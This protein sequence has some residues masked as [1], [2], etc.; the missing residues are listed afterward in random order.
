MKEWPSSVFVGLDEICIGPDAT[1]RDAIGCIDRS[2]RAIAL[3][4]DES[5]RLLDTI[6]DGDVRRAMLANID[7][8]TPVSSLQP[9]RRT[10]PY[11]NPVTALVSA[12]ASDVLQTM[13]EQ[14][15]RQVPLLDD[16][17]R[18]VGLVTRRDLAP[19][20]KVRLEAVV[21]AGGQGARLRPL[22]ADTPKPMLQ[23]AGRPL[24][25]QIIERLEQAGIR[26][27]SIAT[28]YQ[29]E[30]IADHFGDGRAFGI[31][32]SYVHEDRPL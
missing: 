5:H 7:L 29:A 32:L 15:L 2:L 19:S 18:V 26:R 25:E 3:V 27:V 14:G 20:E 16:G 23:V 13:E 11:P 10:S 21:M 12:D 17:R 31:D 28:H 24:M 22:T 8:N 1:I 4:V 6:T 30:K 9:R